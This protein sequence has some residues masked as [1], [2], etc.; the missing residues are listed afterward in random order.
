MKR[1]LTLLILTLAL[2]TNFCNAQDVKKSLEAKFLIEG[3]IQFGGDEILKVF[4][5]NGEDQ[6]INA[7]QGGYLAIGGD[8]QF[9]KVSQLMLRTSIG[10]KY[11]T[12]AASDANITF[13]R[14][15]FN[16]TPYYKINNDFRIGIGL[17][18][19]LNIRLRGDG[20]VPDQDFTSSLGARFE[21]GY[22]WFSIFYTLLDHIDPLNN[23]FSANSIGL[24]I[25]YAFVGKKE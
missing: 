8:F 10:Y 13:T 9:P 20:F 16:L 1:H 14:L 7:G 23:K 18:T 19:D 6:V 2:T 15:P 17:A 21:L 3:G 22:K 12:T 24:S 4:F 11:S 25:S 5:T